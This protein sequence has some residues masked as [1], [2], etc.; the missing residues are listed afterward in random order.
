MSLLFS[1]ITFGK[2][3]LK[4]RIVMSP[5]CT[6]SSENE[7]GHLVPW[8]TVHYGSRAVGQAGLVMVEAT[9]VTPEGRISAR[10]LGIWDDAHT[11][12]FKALVDL[13]HDQG[14][15]A[16]I[17]LAHA[18]RKA[19][20]VPQGVAPS[21]I[22]FPGLPEPHALTEAEVDGVVEAFVRGAARAAEAGFDIVE[23][24]AAHGYLLNEFLS[25]LSNRRE[26][27]YGG[28]PEARFLTVRRVVEG[29]REVFDGPV[30]VRLSV[31]EY[32]EEGST[33][34]DMVYYAKELKALGV[35]LIDCS[36]G[37]VVP[38]KIEVGPGYQVKY[39]AE[40]RS[41]A[42]ILTGAVGIITS[43]T[44]AEEILQKGEADLV[45][46]GRAF[47]K[48]PYW[49]RTAARE[50]GEEIQAPRVYGTAW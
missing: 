15:K 19:E 32:H 41:R 38:A 37:A 40:L 23:V 8:H 2:T 31:N 34:E 42:G 21:A 10:D 11:T 36:S 48:D 26:D 4:N 6:F 30:F 45:F 7:D 28:S 22:A 50:L 35:H 49:P 47:L 44:Q 3:E 25:P 5:M 9:A 16:A 43:G 1:P 12:G 33:M 24:H 13:I 29:I 14:S 46:I 20:G 18:G 27:R 39:A 17:Q